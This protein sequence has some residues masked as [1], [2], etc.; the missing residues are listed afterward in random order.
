MGI[1]PISD[2]FEVLRCKKECHNTPKMGNEK[3]P[4]P[5]WT[6]SWNKWGISVSKV[7]HNLMFNHPD[8]PKGGFAPFG[9]PQYQKFR[10]QKPRSSRS[11]RSCTPKSDIV[12]AVERIAAVAVGDAQIGIVGGPRA[13]AK[14]LRSSGCRT[15]WIGRPI[16]WVISTI[17]GTRMPIIDPLPNVTRHVQGTVRAGT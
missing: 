13:A 2:I 10:K 4:S 5:F 17:V 7:S 15:C 3:R 12:V 14:P 8:S 1:F 9:N 16:I 11:W 6:A